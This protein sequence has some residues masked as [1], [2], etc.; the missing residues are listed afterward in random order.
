MIDDTIKP[1][2]EVRSYDEFQAALCARRDQLGTTNDA[3]DTVAGLP[4]R[5][6]T[7]LL[8]PGQV[9]ILGK[10][11]FGLLLGALGLKLIV[12]EDPEALARV[13][14]RLEPTKRRNGRQRS[15]ALAARA[16]GGRAEVKAFL[17]AYMAGLG[18]LGG[19]ARNAY[20]TISPARRRRIAKAA[21]RGRW[22]K[23]NGA[24]GNG[25]K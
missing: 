16:H 23:A 8:G 10:L 13:A 12:A 3:L 2:A 15:D 18:S 22:G 17:Q 19:K 4:A 21:A 1:L 6:V 24:N 11:S 9:K 7:K 25:V 5:Y 14:N 20:K